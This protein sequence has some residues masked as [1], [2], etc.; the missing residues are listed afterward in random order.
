MPRNYHEVD[1][2]STDYSS[3]APNSV[4]RVRFAPREMFH[5]FA[6][7]MK[8]ETLSKCRM[9][10]TLGSGRQSTLWPRENGIIFLYNTK[11]VVRA[12]LQS[13]DEEV[14]IRFRLFSVLVLKLQFIFPKGF[15]LEICVEN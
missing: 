5:V 1:Q 11:M 10:N 4:S 12:D 9:L 3:D 2:V 13:F 14:T 6:E 8:S 15:K 7:N